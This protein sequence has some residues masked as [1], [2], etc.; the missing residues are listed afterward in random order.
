MRIRN[1]PLGGSVLSKSTTIIRS[2]APVG[3]THGSRIQGVKVG[4]ALLIATP[5]D[6]LEVL[7]LPFP[8]ALGSAG[9][10]VLISKS[11]KHPSEDIAKVPL[12]S[13]FWLLVGHFALPV[14][15]DHHLSGR[16]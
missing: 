9:F 13:K 10:E 1:Y 8:I 4:V 14:L 12:D 2:R 15:G 5:S 11:R 6:P 3:R 7:V 16:I